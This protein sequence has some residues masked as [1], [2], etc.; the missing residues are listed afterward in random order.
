MEKFIQN[1]KRVVRES[2]YKEKLFKREIN[3]VI[4]RKLIEVEHPLRSIEQQYER[5]TNL[6]KYQR[7]SR[8]RNQKSSTENEH[9]NKCQQDTMA[10]IATASSLV[11]KIGSP[12]G[13]TTIEGVR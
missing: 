4:Q 8:K 10:I 2:R 7:E 6:D 13:T 9:A 11:Q 3:G 1:F 12:I 5:V